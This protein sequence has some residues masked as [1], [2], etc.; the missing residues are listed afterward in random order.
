MKA[1]F[2]VGAYL[3]PIII[4]KGLSSA[5]ELVSIEIL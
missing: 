5:N 1:M 3:H 4:F 2:I